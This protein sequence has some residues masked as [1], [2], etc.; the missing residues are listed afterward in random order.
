MATHLAEGVKVTLCPCLFIHR[1]ALIISIIICNVNPIY[2]V[3]RDTNDE[4]TFDF[5]GVYPEPDIFRQRRGFITSPNFPADYNTLE[6][7]AYQIIGPANGTITIR[8]DIIILQP[9]HV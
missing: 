7:C 9:A 1:T 8:S 3:C 4:S 2:C 6:Q 5:P